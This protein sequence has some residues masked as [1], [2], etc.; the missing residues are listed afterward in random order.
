M[1]SLVGSLGFYQYIGFT[2]QMSL[3]PIFTFSKA[4]RSWRVLVCKFDVGSRL[5]GL[6]TRI[7]ARLASNKRP[8]RLWYY[9]SDN[10]TLFLESFL[11]FFF[12]FI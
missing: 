11:S 5:I 2:R 3:Y 8:Y 12:F 6:V 9:I 7:F 10:Q 4:T 1:S